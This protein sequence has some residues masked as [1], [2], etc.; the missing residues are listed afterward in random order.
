MLTVEIFQEII[1]VFKK[2]QILQKT[3]N[4]KIDALSIL[5][6]NITYCNIAQHT[7]IKRNILS[8]NTT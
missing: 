4:L 5:S 3:K 6:Y 1:P 2:Q 7:V 8:Y